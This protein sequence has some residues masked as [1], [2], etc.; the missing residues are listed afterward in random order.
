MADKIDL[1]KNP[2]GAINGLRNLIFNQ[3]ENSINRAA[4]ILEEE[5]NKFLQDAAEL[6]LTGILATAEVRREETGLRNK[7]RISIFIPV[8]GGGGNLVFHV[9]DT[10]TKEPL[11]SAKAHGL[12]AWP[13]H[14]PRQPDFGNVPMTRAGSPELQAA[15]SG[16]PIIFRPFIGQN[17]EPRNITKDI[18]RKTRERLK[19]EGLD[20]FVDIQVNEQ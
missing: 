3:A 20:K 16:E 13:I 12:K 7:K 2:K 1:F 17:I 18:L 4:E 10:G 11:G 9:L 14:L 5:Y 15:F 8:E 19:D 6:G